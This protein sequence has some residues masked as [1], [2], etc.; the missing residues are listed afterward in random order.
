MIILEATQHAE[1]EQTRW[2]RLKSALYLG[3]K[4]R[5][6]LKTVKGDPF[7]FSKI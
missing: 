7:G 6:I 2:E 3:L 1:S 5:K 4:K